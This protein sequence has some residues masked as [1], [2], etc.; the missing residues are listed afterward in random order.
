MTSITEISSDPDLLPTGLQAQ[1]S[2][3]Q[4]VP[5]WVISTL[6][7]IAAI[8]ILVTI[9]VLYRW[10][11]RYSGSFKPESAASSSCGDS[12]KHVAQVSNK[13]R[14]YVSAHDENV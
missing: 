13:P 9:F 10:N 7:V 12:P 3:P 6:V 2:L 4:V 5:F 1:R 8:A 11:S 14:I